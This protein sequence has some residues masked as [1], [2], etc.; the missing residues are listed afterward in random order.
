MDPKRNTY[1]KTF[2]KT[3]KFVWIGAGLFSIAIIWLVNVPRIKKRLIEEKEEDDRKKRIDKLH[4]DR[5]HGLKNN[6]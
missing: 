6:A 4:E 2:Y 5:V 1:N 3:N